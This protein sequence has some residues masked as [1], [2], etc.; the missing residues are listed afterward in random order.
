MLRT[1]KRTRG[2]HITIEKYDHFQTLGTYVQDTEKD[3]RRTETG[4]RQD[5]KNKYVSKKVS[6]NNNKYIQ[7]NKFIEL[8]EAYTADRTLQQAI[9]EY[10]DFRKSINKPISTE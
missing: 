4:Q 10:R 7:D 3:N 1:Q 6:K 2:V 5:T 9:Y 8:V